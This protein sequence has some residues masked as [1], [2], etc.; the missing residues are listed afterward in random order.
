MAGYKT[1]AVKDGNEWVINGN[2]M[3]ITNGTS[4][5]FM[6]V[7]AITQPEAKKLASFSQIIVPGVARGVTRT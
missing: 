3:F 6:V 2:K 5:D 1:R 7:Q 4:C